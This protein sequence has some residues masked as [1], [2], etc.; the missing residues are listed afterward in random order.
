VEQPA[1]KLCSYSFARANFAFSPPLEEQVQVIFSVPQDVLDHTV[2]DATEFEDLAYAALWEQYP[3]WACPYDQR[4]PAPNEF[5]RARH[6][7]STPLPSGPIRI[8]GDTNAIIYAAHALRQEAVL[9][10]VAAFKDWQDLGYSFGPEHTEVE[11]NAL[12]PSWHVG[13]AALQYDKQGLPRS[14]LQ[15]TAMETSQALSAGDEIVAGHASSPDGVLIASS[16]IADPSV[17]HTIRLIR[18][19]PSRDYTRFF[20]M[21]ELDLVPFALKGLL[22]KLA[23]SINAPDEISLP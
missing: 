9:A 18:P 17:F 3:A 12:T 21:D 22:D 4:H 5:E 14:W 7:F 8:L 10:F 15:V 16:V 19:D 13:T 1:S 2:E 11:F 23:A 20:G 6:G